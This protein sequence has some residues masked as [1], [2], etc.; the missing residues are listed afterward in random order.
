MGDINQLGHARLER[1][2]RDTASSDVVVTC[3]SRDRDAAGR[4][5]LAL[6]GETPH[7]RC[8]PAA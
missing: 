2:L 4:E 5:V 1:L 6:G 7:S 3:S 8:G